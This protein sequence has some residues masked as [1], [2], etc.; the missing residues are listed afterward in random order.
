MFIL[1]NINKKRFFI[2]G[3]IYILKISTFE[4]RNKEKTLLNGIEIQLKRYFSVE[5]SNNILFYIY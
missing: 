1:C 4:S 3:I 5:N 2:K